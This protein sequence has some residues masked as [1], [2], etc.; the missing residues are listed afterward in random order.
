L[1]AEHVRDVDTCLF[2]THTAAQ[3]KPSQLCTTREEG[4]TVIQL[5][6]VA[7]RTHPGMAMKDL[8]MVAADGGGGQGGLLALDQ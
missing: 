5:C 2:Y 4:R 6:S 3:S 7:P 8:V 1:A